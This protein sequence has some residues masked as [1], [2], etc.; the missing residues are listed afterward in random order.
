MGNGHAGVFAAWFFTG[1]VVWNVFS[2][3]SGG[4]LNS[5]ENMGA[6]LQKVFIPSYVPVF[7]AT[8]TILVEKS[9]ESLVLVAILLAFQNI[10]WT[11]LLYPAL[12]AVLGV[13]TVS[14]GYILAVANVHFR[15]TKQ[16]YTIV[17]QLFF[18]L[19]PIMYPISMVPET[20]K[21]IP[22]QD[23]ILIEPHGVI[24]GHRQIAHV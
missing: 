8:V 22:L 20:W 13:F 7:A 15:D 23:L 19:T 3:G 18:F 10:G 1:L 21:G 16:I 14:V 11:W 4:G 17:L 6:M 5:I 9:M 12:I 24:C 2:M